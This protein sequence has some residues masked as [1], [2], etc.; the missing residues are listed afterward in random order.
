MRRRC[1]ELEGALKRVGAQLMRERKERRRNER[2]EEQRREELES[3]RREWELN[4]ERQLQRVREECDYKLAEAEE[5]QKQSSEL[6]NQ[7]VSLRGSIEGQAKAF[8]EQEREQRVEL[9][10]RQSVRRMMSAALAL[11]FEAW[12]E[13][14][15]T[16]IKNRRA[17]QQAAA[18][19][20]KPA[21]A[22]S[23]FHWKEDYER[24]KRTLDEAARVKQS[25]DEMRI[26]AELEVQYRGMVAEYERKLAVAL[27][28][29]QEALDALKSDLVASSNEQAERDAALARE[30][31]IELLRRQSMRRILNADL[32][33]GWSAWLELWQ[34]KTYAMSRLRHAGNKLRMP[35]IADAFYFWSHDM[36]EE[37]RKQ[38][39]AEAANAGDKM[40]QAVRRA[41]QLEEELKAT[42]AELEEAAS[43]RDTLRERT[44]SLSSSAAEAA[45]L[46]AQRGSSA[47][48]RS[49]NMHRAST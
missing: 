13:L 44:S 24:A 36:F 32:S 40:V 9:L 35:G 26:R 12:L 45:R 43:E 49:S 4:W 5:Q 15:E 3:K 41:R 39:E 23:Y 19:L 42:R 7:L 16:R 48:V 38:A 14:Y 10:A 11:G 29:K 8:A 37:K 31:R 21:L 33:W 6:E 34:A 28:E 2:E 1:R 27:A 25:S 20:R 30:E 22:G 18:R 46:H 17:L 47:D